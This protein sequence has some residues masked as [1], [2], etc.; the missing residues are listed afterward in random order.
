MMTS[1]YTPNLEPCGDHGMIS[2]I[3]ESTIKVSGTAIE[4]PSSV[5]R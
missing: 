2:C 3:T 1:R 4:T 5:K